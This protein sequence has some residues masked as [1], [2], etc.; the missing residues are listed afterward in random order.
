MLEGIQKPPPAS[1]RLFADLVVLAGNRRRREGGQGR[2]IRH[3]GAV[4][5]RP[6]R[7]HPGA[8]RRRVVR[9]PGAESRR[10]PQLRRQGD[11]TCR[12]STTLIDRANLLGLSA[13]EMTAL[14]GGLRVLGTNFGGHEAGCADRP[15]R[16]VD[17]RLLR[18]PARHGHRVVAVAGRRRNLRRQGP[19]HRQDKWTASRVDLLFG[20][21]SQLRALAEVYAED[22][23]KEKFVNDFVA[24]WV[25]VMDNDRFDL[26]RVVPVRRKTPAD[27]A[28]VFVVGSGRSTCSRR[29]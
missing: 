13:P 6:R 11:R 16:R 27:V 22:D 8:D 18:Q 26:H 23:A 29:R 25:K 24:A 5:L 9:L 15:A 3:R 2:R 17:E 20:S 7:R 10:L 1:T 28:G 19:G 4:Q 12:P 14:V 21:N